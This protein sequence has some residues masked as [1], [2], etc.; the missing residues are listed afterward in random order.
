MER[1]TGNL[2]PEGMPSFS[3]TERYTWSM[4]YFSRLANLSRVP[5]VWWKSRYLA[6][7]WCAY[8]GLK[9]TPVVFLNL[10][11]TLFTEALKGSQSLPILTSL[12]GKFARKIL[13]P[14]RVWNL[15]WPT[16]LEWHYTH[17][18]IYIRSR[19]PNWVPL[20]CPAASTWT[21]EWSP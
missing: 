17:P 13:F 18:G 19:N 5:A 10:S 7:M 12:S 20:A 11:S 21:T 9:Q 1:N 16:S 4:T 6:S 8:R 14:V 15:E 2:H 3:G